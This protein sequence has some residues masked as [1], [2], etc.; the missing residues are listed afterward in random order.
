MANWNS[1]KA[2]QSL[3]CV[4]LLTSLAFGQ[5]P[6]T[7]EAVPKT[8]SV[9]RN[10]TSD[11]SESAPG[12][13]EPSLESI[14]EFEILFGGPEFSAVTSRQFSEIVNP[15]KIRKRGRFYGSLYEFHRN[16]NLDAR[17][18]FDPVG[19][20]LPEFKRNQF[21]ASFGASVTRGLKVFGTFDGLRINRGST[22]L[23]HIPT[24]EMK[25]GDFGILETALIN[26][27][28]GQPFENNVIP[29]D[30]I[31]PVAQ[32]ML[33]EIP[34]ANRDDLDR[35]YVNNLPVIENEDNYSARV[36]YEFGPRTNLF[37]Q[38]RLTNSNGANVSP[39]PS[40]G[41]TERRRSQ[42]LSADVVHNFR[43]EL[44]TSV[45]L[46]ARRTTFAELATASSQTGLL[47]SL[48]IAGVSKLD[49]LDEGFPEFQL[50]GYATLG[51]G[52]RNQ[53]PRTF[54]N[55]DL[56]IA[57]T[58]T[59]APNDHQLSFG[60]EW[61]L[62]QINNNRSGGL[63]R[64]RFEFSGNYTGDAFA[65][66]LLGIPDSAERALGTDRSDLRRQNWK[67]F[68]RDDWRISPRF[69]LSLS[70]TYQYFSP[71]RSV[72]DN[73]S[74]YWPLLFEPPVD[75]ELVVTGSQDDA[76]TRKRQLLRYLPANAA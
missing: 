14:A 50:E 37:G 54:F 47:D 27:F 21:G 42:D 17:N 40:F 23:S 51:P 62:L 31:H 66:F 10:Q 53:S 7:G 25:R 43:P 3:L 58:T 30:L 60:V 69:S 75:G 8:V 63:R 15:F 48:G 67:F 18:F 38:Y 16:D 11:S 35:N 9:D 41:T 4:L 24:R 57:V 32:R 64:G 68:F 29:A 61:G 2:A 74:T 34:E 36:D 46:N 56:E 49:D 22:L 65:D 33:A 70:L 76:G 39:L 26:P 55:N 6:P 20:P 45:R 1:K 59:Y 12:L 5:G 19:E 71:Y 72:H 73:V 13:V 44:V 28:N 52:R